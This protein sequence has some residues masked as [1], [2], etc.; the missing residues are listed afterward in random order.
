MVIE[1][2]MQDENN[3]VHIVN[4]VNYTEKLLRV[5]CCLFYQKKN[6]KGK[7]RKS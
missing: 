5:V 1:F 6:K 7:K 4:T 2:V 3:N